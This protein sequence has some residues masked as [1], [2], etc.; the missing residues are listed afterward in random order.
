[1]SAA[2][3]L[4]RRLLPLGGLSV[5]MSPYPRTGECVAKRQGMHAWPWT[6]RSAKGVA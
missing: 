6:A 4:R 2:R 3:P 1:M 5:H